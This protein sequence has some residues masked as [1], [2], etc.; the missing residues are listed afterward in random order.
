MVWWR[1]TCDTLIN[2]YKVLRIDPLGKCTGMPWS[3]TLGTT[4]ELETGMP[5]CGLAQEAWLLRVRAMVCQNGLEPPSLRAD[6]CEPGTNGILQLA[7]IDH[8]SASSK[9]CRILPRRPFEPASDKE[10]QSVPRR[11]LRG[12]RCSREVADDA[13]LHN[14][15][16]LCHQK[17]YF[18]AEVTLGRKDNSCHCWCRARRIGSWCVSPAGRRGLRY[19]RKGTPVCSGLAAALRS[20]AS[21]YH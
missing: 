21:T 16:T 12:Q 5:D 17:R 11:Q 18:E 2:R 6:R 20:I 14:L 7:K 8:S 4:S 19:F 13:K 3:E 1:T 10:R 15:L 9:R